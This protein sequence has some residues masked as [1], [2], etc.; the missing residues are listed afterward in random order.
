MEP[1]QNKEHEIGSQFAFEVKNQTCG[2][3]TTEGASEVEGRQNNPERSTNPEKVN[4]LEWIDEN[5]FIQPDFSSFFQLTAY[6]HTAN[7]GLLF[8]FPSDMLFIETPVSSFVW[9]SFIEQIDESIKPIPKLIQWDE[10]D[11]GSHHLEDLGEENL[12]SNL[13]KGEKYSHTLPSIDSIEEEKMV[14]PQLKI[15]WKSEQKVCDETPAGKEEKN[16]QP[17]GKGCKCKKT[18]CLKMYCDC[19]REGRSCNG[20][21]CV[22]CCNT[23]E[24]RR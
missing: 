19:F 13:E 1:V 2:A 21:N 9:P 6:P 23:E 18:Q 16:N 3:T 7:T 12:S 5:Q 4:N 15:C 22:G 8:S 17:P 11:S 14:E 20:C 10:E 24:K